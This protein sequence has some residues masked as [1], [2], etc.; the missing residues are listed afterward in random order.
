MAQD[1]FMTRKQ[2][3]LIFFFSCDK[4]KN[5]QKQI[6]SSKKKKNNNYAQK[7]E[8]HVRF[9]MEA[10]TMVAIYIYNVKISLINMKIQ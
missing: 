8:E 10:D 4:T 1:S 9:G 2:F 6:I 7:F 3:N 5:A